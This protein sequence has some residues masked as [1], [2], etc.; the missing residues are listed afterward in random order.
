MEDCSTEERL[1]QEKL[2][3]RQWTDE[4]VERLETLMRQNVVVVWLQGRAIQ[5]ILS[6]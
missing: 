1:R 3:H 4:Y 5:G 6:V 2:C